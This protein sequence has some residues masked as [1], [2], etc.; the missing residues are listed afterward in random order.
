MVRRKDPVH[1]YCNFTLVLGMI[2][3]GYVGDFEAV[4]PAMVESSLKYH[5]DDA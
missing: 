1:L 4:A 2:C 5:P 3:V